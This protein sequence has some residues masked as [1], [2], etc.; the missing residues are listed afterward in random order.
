MNPEE[1]RARQN[2]E[3][4]MKIYTPRVLQEKDSQTV[5]E[6]APIRIYERP[7]KPNQPKSP[8]G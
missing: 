5:L 3:A 1:E 7:F 2:Y 6:H 8:L 4:E